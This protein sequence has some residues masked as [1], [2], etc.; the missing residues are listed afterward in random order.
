MQPYHPLGY[1]QS[2]VPSLR[3]FLLDRHG[4]KL[5]CLLFSYATRNVAC[6]DAWI[7]W[8]GRAHRRHLC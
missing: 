4:R 3:Y 2:I 8:R 1:R 5:G 6:R 7:G